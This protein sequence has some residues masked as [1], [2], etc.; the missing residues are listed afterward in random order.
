[1]TTDLLLAVVLALGGI[2]IGFAVVYLIFIKKE[3]QMDDT[4]VVIDNLKKPNASIGQRFQA[5]F[6]DEIVSFALAVLIYNIVINIGLEKH[7]GVI[8]GGWFQVPSATL[9]LIG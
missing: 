5:Q 4:N 6:Y 1:M 8:L 9:G 2:A 7:V 3:N